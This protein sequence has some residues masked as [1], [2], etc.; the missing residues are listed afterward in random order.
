[1]R[2]SNGD[3]ERITRVVA[4]LIAG[5]ECTAEREL[6]PIAGI[7]RLARPLE[8][9]FLLA[10]GPLLRRRGPRTRDPGRRAKAAVWVRDAFMCRY[11]RRKTIP[12]DLLKIIS[13]R[14]PVAFGWQKNW[15]PPTHRAYWD[16][17]TSLDLWVPE[18]RSP[19]KSALI[20]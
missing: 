19:C 8:P 17:S 9:Q 4:A 20:E 6:E 13:F 14:F 2:E 1:M 12:P 5:D 16:I 7:T 11:C 3:V 18:S 10:R 15:N